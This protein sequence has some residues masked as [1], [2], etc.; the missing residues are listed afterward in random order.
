MGMPKPAPAAVAAFESLIPNVPGVSRRPVFGQPAAFV[1][2]NMFF[3][4]FGS[5]LILRLSDA[6]RAIAATELR[7][8]PFEPMPGRPMREYIALPPA[9]WKDSKSARA[10]VERSVRYASKL[11]AKK[12]KPRR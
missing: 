10:W 1:D 4:V 3:G 5:D 11:P 7:A 6:D 8:L 2:G 12:P 9:V